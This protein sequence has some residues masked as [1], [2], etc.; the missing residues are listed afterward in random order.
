MNLYSK[1][2]AKERATRTTKPLPLGMQR[3]IYILNFV[4]LIYLD[5]LLID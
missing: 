1:S 5:H 3:I 2:S 4:S